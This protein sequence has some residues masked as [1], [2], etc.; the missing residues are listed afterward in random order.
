MRFALIF[1]MLACMLLA[2][3]SGLN[4]VWVFQMRMEYVTPQ[5]KPEAP[6]AKKEEGS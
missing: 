6:Q 3:C 1:P 5:D 4:T 2:G